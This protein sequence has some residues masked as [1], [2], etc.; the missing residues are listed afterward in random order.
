MKNELLKNKKTAIIG[1]GPVG[2]TMARLLQQTGVE[3]K[4]Y[5]WDAHVGIRISGGTLDL[6]KGMGQRA[7]QKAGLLNNYYEASRPT[8]ERTADISGAILMKEFPKSENLY[9]RP[10]IDRNDL[11]A[12]LL[13]SLKPETVVWGKQ[14]ISLEET[15]GR[16][17]IYFE[18][19]TN[20]VADLV[21]GANGGRSKVREHL[22]DCKPEYTGT[23]IIQGEVLDP[24]VK[25]P[26]FKQMCDA[27][28]MA[29][30]SGEQTMLYSQIKA[31]G[32]INYYIGF[33]ESENFTTEQGI[34][35]DNNLQIATFLKK[36]CSSWDNR[37]KE[38]FDATD[39]FSFLPMRKMPL[40]KKWKTSFPLTLIGDAAHVMPPFAGVGVNT[41]LL[42]TLYLSENL[43]EGHFYSIREA[44]EDYENKMFIYARE[45][46]KATSAAE[47]AFFS[48]ESYED[49]LQ[50]REE[51][52]KSL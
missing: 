41:G 7:L 36:I 34:N 45:A 37:F 47:L 38:L 2:L 25:C 16:F 28:N 23:F 43:T 26:N 27:D 42:D 49:R 51:W 20:E 8:G 14:M 13:N 39:H 40:D 17:T 3:V 48:D 22:T 21:I 30:I 46:Q 6:H 50:G 18:D 32:A 35:C 15:E 52:N 33:K 5:E 4:V 19:G 11:R 44:L 1:G 29:V 10:E 31:E 12:I 24:L 9:D